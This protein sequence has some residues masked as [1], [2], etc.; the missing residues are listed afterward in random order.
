LPGAAAAGAAAGAASGVVPTLSTVERRGAAALVACPE[1]PSAFALTPVG[2]VV[3]TAL[4]P[5][6]V[7]AAVPAASKCVGIGNKSL[8]LPTQSHTHTLHSC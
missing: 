7:R 1:V 2:A 4:A 8:K 3:V 5:A 6:E